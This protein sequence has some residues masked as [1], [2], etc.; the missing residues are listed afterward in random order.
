MCI[1]MCT[2]AYKLHKNTDS[3]YIMQIKETWPNWI[4]IS[5]DAFS[6]II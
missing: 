2:D 1:I 6:I 5:L 4:C 3:Y